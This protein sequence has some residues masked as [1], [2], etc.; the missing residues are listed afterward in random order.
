MSVYLHH[1]PARILAQALIQ[2]GLGSNPTLAAAWPVYATYE[3]AH[4]DDVISTYDSVGINHGRT[5]YDGENQE[6][7]GVM[8]RIRST[9]QQVGYLKGSSI[10]EALAILYQYN[11]SIDGTT[12]VIHSFNRSIPLTW[13]GKEYPEG[14]R[15]IHTID[16]RLSIDRL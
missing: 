6:H 1:S 2:L 11:V 10:Q 7:P 13:N 14:A 5:M 8:I 3:P 15:S 4:P 9:T 16:G 12:Y